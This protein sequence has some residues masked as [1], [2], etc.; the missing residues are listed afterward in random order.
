MKSQDIT[1]NRPE[2]GN[3]GKGVDGAAGVGCNC[4]SVFARRDF[5]L[6]CA[7]VI[8]ALGQ[9]QGGADRVGLNTDA[10]GECGKRSQEDLLRDRHVVEKL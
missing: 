5:G 7:S 8:S 6:Q 1:H 3:E 9:S 10:E 4:G 2:L